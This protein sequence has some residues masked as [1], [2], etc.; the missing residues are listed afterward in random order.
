MQLSWLRY[1]IRIKD[2][3]YKA[4]SKKEHHKIQMAKDVG[5]AKKVL[6]RQK[7]TKKNVFNMKYEEKVPG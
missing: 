7:S 6:G 4:T 5:N 2:E 1:L 3:N